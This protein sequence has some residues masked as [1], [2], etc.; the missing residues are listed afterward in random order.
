MNVF[1][2][3]I[4]MYQQIRQLSAEGYSITK[5]SAI[6]SLNRRTIKK[7]LGM[8]EK[9]FEAFQESLSDRK[10][11]LL[12]YEGFVRE[13]LELYRDTS[14]AQMHDWL[15]EHF[16]SFPKVNPKTVFNFVHWIRARYNLP[17]VH[18]VREYETVP[19]S[20]YGKQAQVDFGEYIMR[21]SAGG[22]IKV[23]FFCMML[24]RSR[25]KYVWFTTRN[26]TTE[27]TVVSHEKAFEFF[28]GI[29]QEIVYDQ[30]KVLLVSENKG[31]LILTSVFRAYVQQKDFKLHFC[32]KADPE[33]K[34]KVENVIKYIKSN[35]LYNRT[36]H[37]EETLNDEA[38]AWLGRT[39][40]ALPHSFTK[41]EPREEWII[42][43]PMLKPFVPENV[44]MPAITYMVRKDNTISWKGNFYSVPFGTYRGRSSSVLVRDEAGKL[45]IMTTDSLEELCRHSISVEKGVKIINTDHKRD[46]RLELEVLM[47]SVANQFDNPEAAK[48]WLGAIY[49]IK[50][51]YMR[52]QLQVIQEVL[53]TAECSVIAN[54]VMHFC[55]QNNILSA[56]DFKA[57]IQQ[58]LRDSNPKQSPGVHILNPLS[59]NKL[60]KNIQPQKGQIEDYQQLFRNEKV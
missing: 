48:N 29:P 11:Q 51:R 46:K 41:K 38:I 2:A 54:K 17:V 53:A 58:Q 6:T 1:I 55:N 4:L 24:S 22:R 3:K 16:A 23:F 52:D 40:N 35:F 56:S 25:Y 37:N 20:A 31:D 7:Y 19:E 15:K 12:P 26:F 33:S 59:G 44:N 57:I 14:A 42:E 47:L 36:F 21:T 8:T 34:G 27:L 60:D 39:A 10:K 32:R 43:R 50:S 30:D 5:I 18:Q 28:D 45:I 13:K 9:E 49:K